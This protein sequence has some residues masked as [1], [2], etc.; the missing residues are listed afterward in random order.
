M[1]ELCNLSHTHTY[2]I[3]LWSSESHTHT[4]CIPLPPSRLEFVFLPRPTS[5][6]HR[7]THVLSVEHA[8]PFNSAHPQPLMS[9][10]IIMSLTH[11][12]KVNSSSGTIW[13]YTMGFQ[14]STFCFDISLSLSP[15]HCFSLHF[16]RHLHAHN[17]VYLRDA[18]SMPRTNAICISLNIARY[19]SH[20]L[21]LP[22]S[23][24][25]MCCTEHQD[26][27]VWV[28]YLVGEKDEWGNALFAN[29]ERGVGI[30]LQN[31]H[32]FLPIRLV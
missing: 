8:H 13:I 16:F 24:M 17:F 14:Q 1:N 10:S 23:K 18:L 28:V 29:A 26:A 19:V 15:T 25:P 20:K 21:L 31:C 22:T 5:L 3:S 32:S 27:F 6:S 11:M 7:N 12:P 9:Q 2:L 30:F 4:L